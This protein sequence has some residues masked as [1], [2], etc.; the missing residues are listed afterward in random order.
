MDFSRLGSGTE[1]RWCIDFILG[2]EIRKEVLDIAKNENIDLH[3]AT[4]K[5]MK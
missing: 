1:D 3:Q 5:V 4:L 2:E